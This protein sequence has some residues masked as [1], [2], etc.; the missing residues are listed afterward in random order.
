MGSL[1]TRLDY[2]ER[3]IQVLEDVVRVLALEA[4][5]CRCVGFKPCGATPPLVE[6]EKGN[7]RCGLYEGHETGMVSCPHMWVKP[8]YGFV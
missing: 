2:V 4:G 5:L 7:A 1:E 3:R 6:Q 8:L